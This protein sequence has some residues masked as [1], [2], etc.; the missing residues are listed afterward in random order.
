MTSQLVS[1]CES[2]SVEI[3]GKCFSLIRGKRM[4][5][6]L[7]FA[8][9][10]RPRPLPGTEG[11]LIAFLALPVPGGRPRPL[12]AAGDFAGTTSAAAGFALAGDPFDCLPFLGGLASTA[13]L[14]E[15]GLFFG[16]A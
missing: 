13:G 10:G 1:I 8:F 15:A 5:P 11:F 14:A 9:G 3:K 6:N 2:Y 4:C 7:L 12:F 16:A